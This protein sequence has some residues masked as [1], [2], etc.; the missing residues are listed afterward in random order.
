[1]QRFYEKNEVLFIYVFIAYLFLPCYLDCDWLDQLVSK[2]G[3][4]EVK[5]NRKYQSMATGDTNLIS[6]LE[7][8]NHWP[9]KPGMKEGLELHKVIT[10]KKK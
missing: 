9:Q 10:A 1:M 3:A 4:T 6:G 7:N 2:H 8:E 5:V